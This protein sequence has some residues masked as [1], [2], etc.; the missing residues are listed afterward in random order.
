[1]STLSKSELCP[2]ARL[3]TAGSALF[4]AFALA[5]GLAAAFARLSSP[6]TV[7]DAFL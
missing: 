6:F 3:Y 7:A 4:F 1:M 2:L 5:L